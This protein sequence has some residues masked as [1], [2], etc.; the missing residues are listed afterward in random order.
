VSVCKIAAI[1]ATYVYAIDVSRI[2]DIV[3]NRYV[4]KIADINVLTSMTARE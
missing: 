3:G 2:V 1:E 4:A